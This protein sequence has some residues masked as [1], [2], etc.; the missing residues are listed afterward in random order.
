MLEIARQ[1]ARS[2]LGRPP[3]E[4]LVRRLDGSDLLRDRSG[5]IFQDVK[6]SINA[7]EP[8]GDGFRATLNGE[9][10]RGP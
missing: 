7:T 3:F 10:R 8:A 4:E 1:V 9:A 6:A 2:R 5:D